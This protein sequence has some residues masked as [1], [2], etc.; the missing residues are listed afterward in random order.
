MYACMHV[1]GYACDSIYIYTVQ[2]TYAYQY[3][4]GV[5]KHGL[6]D[7]HSLLCLASGG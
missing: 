2:I 6:L 4:P 3:P 5:V 1:R 7:N